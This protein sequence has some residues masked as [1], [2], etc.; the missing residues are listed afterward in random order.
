MS[1]SKQNQDRKTVRNTRS[2]LKKCSDSRLMEMVRSD[3][4][5]ASEASSV[6]QERLL[7]RAMKEI[8]ANFKEKI[9]PI[10]RQRELLAAL[11]RIKL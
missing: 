4:P 1:P 9:I 5:G 6:Y 7:Q 10:L 8:E 3:A 11:S 2:T